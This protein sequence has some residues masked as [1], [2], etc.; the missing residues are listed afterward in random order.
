[1]VSVAEDGKLSVYNNPEHLKERL[2]KAMGK[3]SVASKMK[4]IFDETEKEFDKD[5]V[6]PEPEIKKKEDA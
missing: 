3:T 2:V 1:M 5:K 6:I 4:D